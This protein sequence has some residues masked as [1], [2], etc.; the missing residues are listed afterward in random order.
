MKKHIL[1]VVENNAVPFDLRVW[2][3]AQAA[4]EFGYD[5]TVIC[6]VNFKATLRYD[7]INGIEIY[8]H[9]MPIEADGKLGFLFEYLNALFWELF[10]SVKIFL[11]KPFHIVHSANPPDHIFIIALLFKLCGAKFIFDHHDLTPENYLAKFGIKGILYNILLIMEKLTFKTADI[12]ISTNESY[13]KIAVNRGNKRKED[14]FVVRNGPDLSGILFMKPNRDLINGFEYLVVYVG[15]IG[16]QEGI[17]NLLNA[18]KH[19]VY[20]KEIRNVK[21]MLVGTG[22][23]W[24]NMVQLSREM[25]LE[26]YVKFTGYIPYED[27]YEV[28]ATADVCVNPEFRNEFTNKSTMVKIMDYMVFGKPI[29]Q[30]ETREG[31]VTAGNAAVYVKKNDELDFAEA[32]IELLN[33]SGKRKTMGEIGRRRI[34]E[35]LNWDKQKTN[36]K[37][38]YEYLEDR[39]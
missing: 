13:K 3:E 38:A 1:F 7:T 30:F 5:V 21:F 27:F 36:L 19:I 25:N 11:R 4:K 2:S 32:I 35:R 17:E 14:V 23:H 15:V 28:L 29:V 9:P 39:R 34:Y 10:L 12:V 18:V 20:E 8:R 22:T 16:K 24:N 26:K 31:R 33:D 37:K 6:P